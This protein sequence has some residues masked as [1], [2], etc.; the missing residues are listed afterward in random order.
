MLNEPQVQEL[1]TE[2]QELRTKYEEP[3]YGLGLRSRLSRRPGN[4]PFR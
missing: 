3:A 4:M 2:N 1:S